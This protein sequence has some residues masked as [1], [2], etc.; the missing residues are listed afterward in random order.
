MNN[1][2]EIPVFNHINFF[3]LYELYDSYNRNNEDIKVSEL[4]KRV[5]LK[6]GVNKSIDFY[7]FVNTGNIFSLFYTNFVVIKELFENEDKGRDFFR[8][9][10]E[11]PKSYFVFKKV[12][13]DNIFY[14][15]TKMRNSI[16]HV[17]YE[18][19]KGRENIYMWDIHPKDKRKRKNF[20]II[21][22]VHNYTNFCL[23]LSEYISKNQ[24]KLNSSIA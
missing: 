7:E 6:S 5:E 17:H 13:K 18:L 9:F 24:N 22:S 4:L 19:D 3:V 16:S 21:G 15:L 11:D 10:K 1:K 23:R 14:F 8:D 2:L 20:E 12:N